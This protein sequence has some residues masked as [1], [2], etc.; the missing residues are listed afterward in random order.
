MAG[1]AGVAAPANPE[2]A[3]GAGMAG[4]LQPHLRTLLQ[5][6]AQRPNPSARWDLQVW[7]TR[8]SQ[9]TLSSN[10]FFKSSYTLPHCCHQETLAS[11]LV[12]AAVE[13]AL[14]CSLVTPRTPSS[15]LSPCCFNQANQFDYS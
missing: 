12:A 7:V 4:R 6:Y 15:C 9:S 3:V 1:S 13:E 14:S 8:S 10:S 5:P 11:G 2:R